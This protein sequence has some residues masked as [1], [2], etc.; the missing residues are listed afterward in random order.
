MSVENVAATDHSIG[1]VLD[2]NMTEEYVELVTKGYATRRAKQSPMMIHK[3]LNNG[4]R[5]YTLCLDEYHKYQSR[6]SI[7]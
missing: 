1:I 7:S 3:D 2:V 6:L 4:L 5:L